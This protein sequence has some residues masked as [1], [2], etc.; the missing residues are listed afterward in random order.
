MFKT[1]KECLVL[2]KRYAMEAVTHARETFN[3]QLDYSSESLFELEH[4]L[5][6]LHKRMDQGL[7]TKESL[8]FNVQM[9]GSYFGEV[10]RK[11]HGG[12]WGCNKEWSTLIIGIQSSRDGRT[13]WP[14]NQCHK[15]IL[16]GSVQ[17]IKEYWNFMEGFYGQ[18]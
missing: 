10:Y 8:L 5:G 3:T 17:S 6:K 9:Y 13:F 14:W 7:L 16:S 1:N 4:I 11:K 15:K 18:V 2:A 12:E